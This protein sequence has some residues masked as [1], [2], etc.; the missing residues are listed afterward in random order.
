MRRF[1]SPFGLTVDVMPSFLSLIGHSAPAISKAPSNLKKVR[2]HYGPPSEAQSSQ[3]ENRGA[4][5]NKQHHAGPDTKAQ[6]EL[7][8]S[9]RGTS[10]GGPSH[11]S[12]QPSAE[13]HLESTSSGNRPIHAESTTG[14]KS[15][16]APNRTNHQQRDDHHLEHPLPPSSNESKM[17]PAVPSTQGFTPMTGTETPWEVHNVSST[18]SGN[19]LPSSLCRILFTGIFI[20]NIRRRSST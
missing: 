6:R 9:E 7:S 15:G 13:N 1:S 5:P 17:P 2:S 14:Q 19:V 11:Y 18:K 8:P 12:S 4:L 3:S 20:S 10:A 16:S